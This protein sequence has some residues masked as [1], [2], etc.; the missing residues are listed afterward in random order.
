[1]FPLAF[2][3]SLLDA[4]QCQTHQYFECKPTITDAFDV[5]EEL[6]RV[7]LRLIQ[8]P[9]GA[10]I[11]RFHRDISNDRN[12]HIRMCFQTERNDR[13][14]NEKDRNYADNLK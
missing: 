9:C 6:V 12:S 1:M 7:C 8:S 5:E 14:A 11:G 4:N 13:Y 2:K 3:N 10:M